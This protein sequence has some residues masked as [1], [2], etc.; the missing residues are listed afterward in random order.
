MIEAVRNGRLTEEQ[1]SR[2]QRQLDGLDDL[3]ETQTADEDAPGD[4][5]GEQN[6]AFE[7]EALGGTVAVNLAR[8]RGRAFEGRRAARQG[9][10]PDGRRRRVQVRKAPR[11]A[12]RPRVLRPEAHRLHRAPRHGNL[13]GAE[14]RRARLYRAGRVNPRRHGLP[15]A[16]A[17]GRVLPQAVERGRRQLPRGDGRCRRGHQPPV[18]LAHG[19]LRHPVE[20][21]PPRAAD[22]PY[23][24]IRS[25]PSGHHHQP[26]R[27]GNPRGPGDEDA[28][29][30]AAGHP[31]GVAVRQGVRCHRPPVRRHIHEGL[32]R[33]GG[34]G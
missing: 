1:L 4:G 11:G 24:P 32:P 2:Q 26:R 14:A 19:Q 34:Y 9:A 21:R 6:E 20:P 29:R 12:P 3:F 7:D 25:D 18:L 27:G 30:Q 23:P 17:A 28:A 15:G 5:D 13:P 33:S 8:A 16:R 31:A 10:E 22:G